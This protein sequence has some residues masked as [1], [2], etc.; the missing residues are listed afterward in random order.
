MTC[1]SSCVIFR[2]LSCLGS[3]QIFRFVSGLTHQHVN[4]THLTPLV[5]MIDDSNVL[6][7]FFQ[8]GD[9]MNKKHFFILCPIKEGTFS[10]DYDSSVSALQAFS[11]CISALECRKSSQHQDSTTYVAKRVTKDP[12]PVRFASLP[13]LSPVGRV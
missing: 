4:T 10:V 8:Q 13:P 12:K 6:R 1:S 5:L 9:A 11:V 7:I 3:C 2:L